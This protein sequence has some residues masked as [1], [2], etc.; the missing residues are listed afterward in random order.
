MVRR[1]GLVLGIAV[2]VVVVVVASSLPARTAQRAAAVAPGVTEVVSTGADGNESA[3]PATTPVV[4]ADGTQVAFASRAALDPIVQPGPNT[5]YNIYVRDRRR[6]GRTVLISRGIP[7]TSFAFRGYSVPIRAAVTEE[8]GNADSLH[9]AISADGR[10]VAFDSQASNLRDWYGRWLQRIVICDRDPD[11]DGVFDEIGPDGLM[12]F[13][14]LYLTAPDRSTGSEPSLSAAGTVLAWREQVSGGTSSRIAVT[15]LVL[16]PQG[17]PLPPDPTAFVH[18]ESGGRAESPQ[19]SADGR[20]LVF[21]DGACP[22]ASLDCPDPAGSIQAYELAAARNVRIDYLP[23]GS[24]SGT[25]AHPAISGSGRLIAYEHALAPAGPVVTVVVDRDPAGTGRL[26]P[27]PGAPVAASIASTDDTGQPAEGTAPA[28]STDGRYLAYQ[29]SARKGTESSI[30][31]RDLTLDATRTESKLPRLPS[32]LGSPAAGGCTQEPCPADGP[33]GSPRLSADGSVVVFS[34]A[35][36]DLVSPPCCAGAAFARLLRPR[37]TSQATVFG[38]VQVGGAAARTITLQH[39]GFGPLTISALRIAGDSGFVVGAAENCAGATLHNEDTCQLTVEFRPTSTGAKQA[40]L[41]IEQRDGTRTDLPLQADAV[42]VPPGPP[43]PN[44]TP[45]APRPSG[46]LVVTPDPVDLGGVGPALVSIAPRTV[47]VRNEATTPITIAAIGILTGPRFT[48]GDF[49]V[50]ATTCRGKRLNPGDTCAIEVGST[51]QAPGARSGVLAVTAA[52]PSYSRLVQLSSRAAVP[53]L[54]VNPAVVRPNR[55]TL[56][57][58]RAFPPG[59]SVTLTVTTPGTELRTTTTVGADG[60]L[61]V[62]LL[63]FPQTSP[64]SRP[65]I[66]TVAGTSIRA[67]ASLLVVSGSFQPPGFTSRR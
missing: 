17:R 61:S 38:A 36:A 9:P 7:Q 47:A 48:A 25:A 26:G 29:G 6:P 27:G 43:P 66:A 56:V 37:V 13:G 41:R 14:Y 10:Y 28:L 15:R 21:T 20:H 62:P 24:F 4:S 51:P 18:P 34:S 3:G 44:P 64:G 54:M 11:N 1:A 63:V 42:P 59:S 33:S 39:T 5:P 60:R 52:D 50:A 16:D 19:V 23:D 57:T 55:V 2:V 31:L 49:A 45:S 53:T 12:E 32:E 46:G 30:L 58:G 8:G 67:Q 35:A 40:I 65:V 22:E